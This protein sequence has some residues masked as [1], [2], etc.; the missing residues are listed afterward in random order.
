M[1][2]VKKYSHQDKTDWDEFI[3]LSKN[4]HFMFLRD[5]MDYHSDRFED[6]SLI[7]IDKRNR[8]C[9]I[10]PA[11]IKENAL[12][13]HQGLTFGGL[14]LSE[15]VTTA[16]VYEMFESLAS[17]CKIKKIK[18]IIYKPIPYIYSSLPSQEDLYVLFIQQA[19]ILRRD[20]SS[21][22]NLEAPIRYS[23]GRKWSINKAKKENIQVNES[24]DYSNFWPL[25][26]Q[27]LMSH[28]DAAPVHSLTEIEHL[29]KHFPRNIRLF[30]AEHH[31]EII[32][33]AVIYETNLVAHTQYLANS[34]LGRALGG[35][36]L[37]LDHLIKNVYK[38]KK[39]FDFGIST[40]N[41]GLFLNL[42][43]IA[44]KEGF[45]ASAVVHDFYEI[46]IR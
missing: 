4:G 41:S 15:K 44:Q 42:G 24:T 32:A 22:I 7:L 35:L 29:H 31:G 40:E 3:K 28:H 21:S 33:G 12:Y 13:S 34:E 2:K 36:D 25:L 43:L 6:N 37:I 39:Y 38:D 30:T 18:K 1:V 16:L 26:S 14:V 17:Y 46:N 5:Y 23:K 27:V 9:A 20:V 10:F 19:K 11:N 8:I 45:G